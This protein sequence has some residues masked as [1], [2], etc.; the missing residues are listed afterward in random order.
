MAWDD[1]F[2]EGCNLA[3]SQARCDWIL[4]LNPDEEL[5][6]GHELTI[7]TC[8]A[9][10]QVLGYFVS[11]QDVPRAGRLDEFSVTEQ[12]RLFRRHPELRY[13]GRLHPSFSVPL[14]DLARR[15]GMQVYR[16]EMTLRRHAYLSLLDEGKLRWTLRL[17]ER[18]LHD[19]PGQLHYQIQLGLTLLRLKD[20]EG[21]AV[22]GEA[23]EQLLP[24]QGAEMPP[25][26]GLGQLLEYLLTSARAPVQ[27]RFPRQL[28]F[29][30]AQRW[31]PRSP[32]LAWALAHQCFARG[33]FQG[34]AR[35]LERLVE[36]GRTGDYDRSEAFDPAILGEVTLM[37]LGSCYTRL[38]ELDRAERCFRQLL[39]NPALQMQASENL[40]LLERL[41][42]AR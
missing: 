36:F 14:S 1:D 5:L 7:R 6:P 26:P 23:A 31:F 8:L 33:D 12:P 25:G 10:E 17:L 4:W 30:L 39:T 40:G 28:A 13:V 32:P 22:L 42:Q 21:H 29:D 24:L 11:V 9:Q 27:E 41:R 19:R 20:S 2:A 3:L 34:A 15:E 18:E 35:Q 16:S 37:N 38:G